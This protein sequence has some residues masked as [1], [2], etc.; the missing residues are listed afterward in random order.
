MGWTTHNA[1]SNAEDVHDIECGE[2]YMRRLED[3][4]ARIENKV[5]ALAGL[6]SRTIL[7]AFVDVLSQTREVGLVELHARKNIYAV[8]NQP[9]ILNP[10]FATIPGLQS[11]FGQRHP[12]HRQ[13]KTWIDAVAARG[14]AVTGKRTALGPRFRSRRPIACSNDFEDAGNN[15]LRQCVANAGRFC[16]GANFNAFTAAGASG[17]HLLRA[18]SESVFKGGFGHR[19]LSKRPHNNVGLLFQPVAE[20]RAATRRPFRA[21]AL[22]ALAVW[23]PSHRHQS[24]AGTVLLD[25]SNA[26]IWE[27]IAD[28]RQL[29]S[30]NHIVDLM[31]RS[32]GQL[33]I[34]V[35]DGLPIRIF[36]KQGGDIRY[37]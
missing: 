33:R 37:V 18:R 24:I 20:K 15:A 8:G 36:H 13:Q 22:I 26:G 5:G 21:K 3:V 25:V 23:I 10:L 11:L 19:A 28:N 30:R 9:K 1:I 34:V 14:D 17:E 12:R 7:Q 31:A 4:A 2:R 6:C 16:G 35:E 27:V 29:F 32:D